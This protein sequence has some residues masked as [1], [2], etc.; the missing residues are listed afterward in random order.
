MRLCMVTT[1]YPPYHFGGDAVFVYRLAE[2]LAELGHEV[3]VVHSVDAYRLGRKGEPEVAFTHHPRVRRHELRSGSPRLAAL[4]AH[5]L[6]S[7][8]AYGRELAR[9][10]DAGPDV[11]HFHNV[12]LVG[13]PGVLRMGRGVKLY[14]AHE[15][16]LV[17]PT[18]VLF[19]YDR[20]ACVERECLG[21]TLHS[22][23]PPQAWRQGGSLAQAA[24]SID[25]FLMPSRF[26]LEK[27]RELGLDAPME[28]LPHFVPP[29]RAGTPA[30][31]ASGARPYFLYTGRLERLKGVQDLVRAFRRYRAADLVIA[32]TGAHE[33]E[34]RSLASDLPHVRFAGHLHPDALDGLYAN[35]VA[36]LAPS[37]CYETFGL[38]VAEALQ[39]GTPAIARRIG[40]LAE[41]IEETG[42]GLSFTEE[43]GLVA[44]MEKLQQD[45][46]L[47]A[48]LSAQ[49]RAAVARL[50]SRER[51]LERYLDLV[52]AIAASAGQKRQAS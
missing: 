45:A 49:G 15:Y 50:F 18:H 27:H 24:R 33:A 16:W 47:R 37:L 51:H 5:Q 26:A 8:A 13:G 29:A 3:D 22:R 38:T 10:L 31:P 6:G 42:G 20:E 23:R 36:M 43:E 44:A 19:K 9:V 17:C 1:F 28:H 34:L 7:P 48:R 40:A 30:A 2:G 46:E 39:R 52:R 11:V 14:T 21:C 32:G 25:R 12:S 4:A 41:M 35:A